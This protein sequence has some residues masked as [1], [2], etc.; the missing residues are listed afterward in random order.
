MESS[1]KSP[2]LPD[3]SNTILYCR[4]WAETVRF[5]REQLQFPV[6]FENEWFV[7]F[8][9]HDN[10]FLSVA[11]A[12]RATIDAVGG[13]GITLAWRVDDVHAA[14]RICVAAGI[15]TTAV[16]QRWGAHVFYCHDPEGHR[17]EFWQPA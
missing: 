9:L 16:R 8:Q 4:R 17:I 14:R 13:Q 15:E 1:G 12:A 11:D 5:Y 7:E 3:R 2:I 6:A 10:A